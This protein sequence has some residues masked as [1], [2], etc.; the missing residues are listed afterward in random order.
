MTGRRMR[1]LLGNRGV[2]GTHHWKWE[3]KAKERK[4]RKRHEASRGAR[5]ILPKD[6]AKELGLE[7]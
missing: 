6:K 7:K 5:L 3:K 1:G 4:L 2:R